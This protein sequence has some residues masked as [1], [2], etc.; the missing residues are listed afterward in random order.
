MNGNWYHKRAYRVK[1]YKTKNRKNYAV[2]DACTKVKYQKIIERHEYSQ[3][4]EINKN[5][6]AKNPERHCV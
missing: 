2:K 5:N 1:Q 4:L 3:A 6:S